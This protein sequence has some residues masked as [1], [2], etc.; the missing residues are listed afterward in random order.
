MH[1]ILNLLTRIK[2]QVKSI[3]RVFLS[4]ACMIYIHNMTMPERLLN[5][6]AVLLYL[7]TN[8]ALELY[9]PL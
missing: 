3:N 7:E 8:P 1:I 4:L 9:K 2:M 6:E 5:P